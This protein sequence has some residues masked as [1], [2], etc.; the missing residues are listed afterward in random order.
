MTAPEAWDLEVR[1]HLTPYFTYGDTGGT[2]SPTGAV[3]RERAVSQATTAISAVVA[4]AG[5]GWFLIVRSLLSITCSYIARPA[6]SAS[7]DAIALTIARCSLAEIGISQPSPRLR[8]RNRL[9]S[10]ISFL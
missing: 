9:S 2:A 8:R 5:R 7:P 3:A 6:A 1:P 10:L 4:A